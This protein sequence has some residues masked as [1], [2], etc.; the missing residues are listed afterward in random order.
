[1][2]IVMVYDDFVAFLRVFC[3]QNIE[4]FQKSSV[5]QNILVTLSLIV[6]AIVVCNVLI[7]KRLKLQY[8]L[9]LIF[10]TLII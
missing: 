5:K 7:S 1:M 2:N 4:N 8:F 10:L 9:L 6:I 3:N